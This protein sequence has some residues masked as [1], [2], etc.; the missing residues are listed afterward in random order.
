[1]GDYP[2]PVGPHS[3]FKIR[4][5]ATMRQQ[6]IDGKIDNPEFIYGT[7]TKEL[8][9]TRLEQVSEERMRLGLDLVR[10]SILLRKGSSESRVR[11]FRRLNKDLYGEPSLSLSLRI[12]EKT[13]DRVK[14]GQEKLWQYISDKVSSMSD[15]HDGYD[16]IDAFFPIYRE[17][18]EMYAHVAHFKTKSLTGSVD[19]LIRE[20]LES[21][22]LA[23]KGWSVLVRDND[24]HARTVYRKRYI[25][26]GSNYKPRSN[27]AKLR[28][29]I[30]EVFGHALAE[31]PRPE[32]ESEGF[33]T[34]LEQLTKR[35][36]TF[37]RSYRYLAVALGWGVFCQPMTF[38]EVYEIIW[39]AMVIM[40]S[41][42]EKRA[43]EHAFNECAR[44]FRGGDPSIAG[45][46]FLKDAQYFS[47]NDKVWHG[48]TKK[49]LTYDEFVAIIE[50][51]RRVLK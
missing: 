8:I 33:A 26:I 28:I 50:G 14:P 4:N 51:R 20:A 5:L 44:A 24:K 22:G 2:F 12:L 25:S 19:E 43:K 11:R 46:V 27:H 37:R 7:A 36:Y 31:S 17:Y 9:D 41:Y 40:S 13:K 39:R 48:L 18:L 32:E 3:Y 47:A 15:E 29:M 21:T 10:T 1:M 30:H 34:V 35:Q 45:A 23:Q 16:V 42:S 38:R 49:L 6:F